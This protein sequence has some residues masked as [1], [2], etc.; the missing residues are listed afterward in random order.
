MSDAP[1][2]K[3]VLLK[4]SGESLCSPGN[5][6]IDAQAV[7]AVVREVRSAVDLGVQVAIVIGGGNIIRGRQL[8]D[9]HNIQRATADYMGMMATVIN[10]LLLRDTLV[11]S[12][13]H[14]ELFSAIS[15]PSICQGWNRRLAIETLEEGKVLLLAGGTGNPFFTTDTCAA[16]RAREIDAE[17]VLKATKVDGVF[18]SDPLTNSAAQRYDRLTY[19]KVLADM[20]GVMDLTAI[21]LCMENHIPIIVFKL[22]TPGNLAGVICGKSIGTLVTQ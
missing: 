11:N 15:M 13:V 10:G 1:R 2:Y 14:A 21:S 12:G 9:N 20:L 18:D 22:A 6:G 19:Q 4:I 3:R 16:L 5:G 8:A 7:A 17:V